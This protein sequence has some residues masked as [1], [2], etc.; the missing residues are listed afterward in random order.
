MTLSKEKQMSKVPDRI[1]LVQITDPEHVLR[2]DVDYLCE[3]DAIIYLV[4]DSGSAGKTA[5]SVPYPCYCR[6]E[7]L[8]APKL[9]PRR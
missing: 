9:E 6:H 2:A 3:S 4:R 1:E 8:P 5:G 7:D